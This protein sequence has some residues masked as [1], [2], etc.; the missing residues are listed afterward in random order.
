[1]FP[2]DAKT[3]CF[4]YVW[5]GVKSITVGI[6]INA[7]VKE[8]ICW[9]GVKSIPVTLVMY[10]NRLHFVFYNILIHSFDD[11]LGACFSHNR[12]NTTLYLYHCDQLP[13]F[14]WRLHSVIQR[15][16]VSTI[17]IFRFIFLFPFPLCPFLSCINAAKSSTFTQCRN[18]LSTI[19]LSPIFTEIYQHQSNKY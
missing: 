6:A 15:Q 9:I 14:S 10:G 8:L 5:S 11:K 4:L 13:I 3:P 16:V 18:P 2:K 1:M 19:F 17:R 12:I 7:C